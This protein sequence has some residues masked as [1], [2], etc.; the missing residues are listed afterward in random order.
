MS[1]SLE[2][3]VKR[4][5]TKEPFDKKRITNAIIKA[6][7]HSGE[8]NRDLAIKITESVVEV[9]HRKF[10]TGE[11]PQ[12][13]IQDVVEKTLMDLRFANTAKLYILYRHRRTLERVI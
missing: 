10:R 9:L 3:C 2:V 1:M 11:F 8:G 12:E 6:F 5:N 13:V 7:E 4:D